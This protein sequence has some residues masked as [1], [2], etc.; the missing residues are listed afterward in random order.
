MFASVVVKIT[1]HPR[2][3][4]KLDRNVWVQCFYPA[5]LVATGVSTR[6]ALHTRLHY[7]QLNFSLQSRRTLSS[8]DS[9][10][11]CRYDI[12]DAPGGNPISIVTVG[13]TTYH[14]WICDKTAIDDVYCMT[15][16]SCTIDGGDIN[17][18]T[19]IIDRNGSVA[20][21]FVLFSR[22]V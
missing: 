1:F 19:P 15:V 10:P 2:F 18:S 7:S 5:Q 16:H 9:I 3:V 4:S 8:S 22:L 13:Q 17:H 6:H 21:R 14:R 12:L 11:V 20:E